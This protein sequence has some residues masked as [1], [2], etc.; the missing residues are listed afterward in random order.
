MS[1]H[2]RRTAKSRCFASSCEEVPTENSICGSSLG[3]FQ[4][5]PIAHFC[6]Q[7][8]RGRSAEFRRSSAH[9]GKGPMKH[10]PRVVA[11]HPSGAARHG[12]N[13]TFLPCA[14]NVPPPSPTTQNTEG[15]GVWA[16][17]LR[18]AAP[19][20]VALC[21]GAFT[22]LYRSGWARRVRPGG[23]IPSSRGGQQ[24]FWGGT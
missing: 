17:H 9:F 20:S 4:L 19:E 11:E 3:T 16:E 10:A 23:L 1:T 24:D 5:S 6:G 7:K 12:G 13:A 22:C 14:P 2:E 8:S 18:W 21:L 15:G